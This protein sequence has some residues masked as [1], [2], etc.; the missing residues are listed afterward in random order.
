MSLGA[1]TNDPLYATSVAVNN[2]MLTGL[3]TVVAAG[4]AGPNEKTLGSPGTAA[5]GISVGASDASM[6]IPAFNGSASDEKF[7]NHAAARQR[8]F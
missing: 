6:S 7:E 5:L 1:Q 3:V 2:A 4:N 8:F